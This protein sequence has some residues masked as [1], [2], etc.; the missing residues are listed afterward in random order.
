M[1]KVNSAHDVL[2]IGGGH[3][4]LVSAAYLARAGFRVLVLERRSSLGGAASTVEPFPGFNFGIGAQD[5]GLLLPEIAPD[6]ELARHGLTLFDSPIRALSLT[7]DAPALHLWREPARA[8][9]D[10]AAHSSADAIAYPAFL[11]WAVRLTAVLGRALTLTPPNLPELGPVSAWLGWARFALAIRRLGR[12]G[13]MGLLRTIPLSVESLLDDWFEA[14]SLKGALGS[15]G[16]AGSA[17][18]PKAPGTALMMLYQGAGGL[19]RPSRFVSGGTARLIQALASAAR[20]QGAEI[21]TEAEVERILLDDGRAIGVRLANG[22]EIRASLV[23]SSADP[24]HTLFDLVGP[25]ELELRVVR[26]IQNIRFR[27]TTARMN[28][29]V[30]RLPKFSGVNDASELLGHILLCPSL[31]YLERAYDDSKYGRCSQQPYLDMVIPS[32]HDPANGSDG[33]QVLSVTMQYAPYRLAGSSWEQEREQLGD[34]IVAAMAEYAPDLPGLVLHR[35]VI[36]PLDL[37]RDYRLPEG[38]FNHG[39]MGL[40]QLLSMRPI[41][42]HARYRSPVAGL[43]FCGAGAHP[44][45]GL[46]GAPGYNA[47]REIKLDLNRRRR[48]KRVS[49]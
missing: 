39:E 5:A 31:D 10:L 41:P 49:D 19:P 8:A 7:A 6:L 16:V 14:P 11:T 36:T 34:R 2:I 27:G 22:E 48:A 18:G 28:L 21:R 24:R 23:A 45:G 30:R 15:L 37:E 13:M 40:D 9:K 29:A 46:T 35:Q 43:Y 1:A 42:G 32:L 20:S 33:S 3:N 25:S 47:A 12:T 44:G 26:R 38:N 17:Q 4:G